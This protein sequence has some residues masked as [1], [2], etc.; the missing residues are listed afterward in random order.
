MSADQ[1]R[2][3]GAGLFYLFIFLSGFWL[4]R[5]GKPYNG[6]VFN[7]HKLIALAAVVIFVTA[8]YQINRMVTLSAVELIAGVA[9]GVFFLG[10][11]VSGGLL[12]I[13]TPMPTIVLK[14]HHISPYLAVFS[15]A[16]T[17]YLLLNHK[18]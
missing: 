3:A 16:V 15:T 6:I 14:L 11:F 7:V 10:L 18:L 8:L 4:S 13:D 2:I 1:L 5:S 12:S 17:L 9:T